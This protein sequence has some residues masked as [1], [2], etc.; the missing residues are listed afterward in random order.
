MQGFLTCLR[1]VREF[2]RIILT[3]ALIFSTCE[4]CRN[5]IHFTSPPVQDHC[6]LKDSCVIAALLRVQNKAVSLSVAAE[7]FHALPFSWT[8]LRALSQA[9][10]SH[11]VPDAPRGYFTIDFNL[12]SLPVPDHQLATEEEQQAKGCLP[13]QPKSVMVVRC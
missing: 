4:M 11:P 2:Q 5:M 13:C 10:P 3:Y 6:Y 7:A 9:H 1:A 12:C 8:G